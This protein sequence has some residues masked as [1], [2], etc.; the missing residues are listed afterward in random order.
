MLFLS[1]SLPLQ[2]NEEHLVCNCIINIYVRLSIFWTV[3]GHDWIQLGS[4][5]KYLATHVKTGYIHK[6][7]L[8]YFFLYF[9]QCSSLTKV[10]KRYAF[11]LWGVQDQ[12]LKIWANQQY[13][14]KF[15]KWH[16]CIGN[17][18][19]LYCYK[20]IPLQEQQKQRIV[21]DLEPDVAMGRAW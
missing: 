9:T 18:H 17:G 12:H 20:G 2:S 14:Y 8:I 15:Y 10:V 6:V 1:Y 21:I 7:C 13:N 16:L 3:F 11:M 5:A 4:G 19:G